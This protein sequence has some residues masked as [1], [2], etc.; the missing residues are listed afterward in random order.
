MIPNPDDNA[1]FELLGGLELEVRDV[2]TPH[3]DP[4]II[5]GGV[6]QARMAAREL[7]KWCERSDA[8][9]SLLDVLDFRI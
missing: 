2:F 6:L 4:T 1:A 8:T 3:D 5:R 7:V 9:Q